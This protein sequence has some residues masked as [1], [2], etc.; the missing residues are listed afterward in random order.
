MDNEQEFYEQ[1]RKLRITK[2]IVSSQALIEH[3]KQFQDFPKVLLAEVFGGLLIQLTQELN[4]I[5]VKQP[6]VI[7]APKTWWDH[8]KQDKFPKWLLKR[9]PAKYENI[10]VLDKYAAMDIVFPKNSDEH[11]ILLKRDFRIQ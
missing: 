11:Y 2:E 4:T 1:L 9:F 10:E 5:E 8:F 7:S 3:I 6:K